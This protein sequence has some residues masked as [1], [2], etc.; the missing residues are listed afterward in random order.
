MTIIAGAKEFT[1][2]V[3]CAAPGIFCMAV[4]TEIAGREMLQVFTGCAYP[5]MTQAAIH[6]RTSELASGM[7]VRAFDAFMPSDQWEARR[8]VIETF[9]FSLFGENRSVWCQQ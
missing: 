8:E 2:I 9:W 4:I 1:V 3:F 6:G 7:A 5:V